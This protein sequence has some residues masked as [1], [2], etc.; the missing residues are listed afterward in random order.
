MYLASR[1]ACRSATHLKPTRVARVERS[2]TLL[3]LLQKIAERAELVR[4]LRCRRDILG[5]RIALGGERQ[6]DA[7]PLVID[8]D[9]GRLY[10]LTDRDDFLRMI[11][12]TACAELAD[13]HEAFDARRQLD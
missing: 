13:V 5:A 2:V 8:R 9:Y 12:A 10:G 1:S 7:S 11:D 4:R 6:P 3:L